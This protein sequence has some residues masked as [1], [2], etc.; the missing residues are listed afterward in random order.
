MPGIGFGFNQA[1][2]PST[3]IPI[4]TASNKM[5]D[6][7]VVVRKIEQLCPAGFLWCNLRK[8]IYSL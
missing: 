1:M 2:K 3:K 4:K 7:L 8:K 5:G 6:M